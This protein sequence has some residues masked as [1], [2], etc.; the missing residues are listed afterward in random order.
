MNEGMGTWAGWAFLV[1]FVFGAI[2][3]MTGTI[4]DI[5]V[6]I[7]GEELISFL[8][9]WT[10]VAV[11]VVVVI[12]FMRH[13]SRKDVARMHFSVDPSNP[14]AAKV[15]EHEARGHAAVGHGV[16]GRNIRAKIES[17]YSGW[18]EANMKGLPL[19]AVMAFIYGGEAMSGPAGCGPDRAMFNALAKR[20][21]P[22]DRG[23]LKRDAHSLAHWHK[24]NSFGRTVEAEMRR[25]GHYR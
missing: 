19:A 16:G 13:A 25:T 6:F 9:T 11:V 1:V 24:N 17:N 20:A 5:A 8:L 21:K 4:D 22:R 18:C 23:R 15:I 7:L 2:A 3:G 14:N 12:A 10:A